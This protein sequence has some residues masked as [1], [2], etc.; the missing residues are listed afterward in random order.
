VCPCGAVRSRAGLRVGAGSNWA[1]HADSCPSGAG[2]DSPWSLGQ[3][4]PGAFVSGLHVTMSTG[5][6]ERFNTLPVPLAEAVFARAR[7]FAENPYVGRL[8][9]K[10]RARAVSDRELLIAYKAA[11][12]KVE[13]DG[14]AGRRRVRGAEAVTELAHAL[15][16]QHYGLT[17]ETVRAFLQDARRRIPKATAKLIGLLGTKTKKAAWQLTLGA[18]QG[19]L[20]K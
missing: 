2:T 15:V 18:G 7:A 4:W 17:P 9:G 8:Q 11:R 6:I 10:R 1:G 5:V 13:S 19:E 14:A 12:W 16:G 3:G 20:K